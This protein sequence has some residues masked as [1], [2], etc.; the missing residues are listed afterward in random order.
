VGQDGAA[1]RSN[2][3]AQV[4]KR[5]SARG[6]QWK[7][8][9]VVP[10]TLLQPHHGIEQR[11]SIEEFHRREH[12]AGRL[13]PRKPLLR[14][15]E[16]SKAQ[17]AARAQVGNSLANESKRRFKCSALADRRKLLDAAAAERAGRV[18]PQDL[19]QAIKFQHFL[20]RTRHKSS[21]MCSSRA[22][23]RTA[24]PEPRR[25]DG[26]EI[27]PRDSSPRPEEQRVWSSLLHLLL[28]S[29]ASYPQIGRASC[30]ERVSSSWGAQFLKAATTT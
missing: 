7:L 27:S 21:A 23:A 17:V 28:V 12:G 10:E 22:P 19:P 2:Q 30:R 9:G 8:C 24:V 15:G 26:K 3:G 11:R 18:A 1:H 20:S 29:L 16:R 6:Q 4:C 14:V 25:R 13:E 5:R